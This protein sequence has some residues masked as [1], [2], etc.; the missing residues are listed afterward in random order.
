VKVEADRGED[1]GIVCEIVQVHDMRGTSILNK[2]KSST[3]SIKRIL[4]VATDYECD[5]LKT[6]MEEEINIVFTC[7]DI[8]QSVYYLPMSV[9]DAEY[10]FDR[11]KL[12]IYY[13]A[14]RRIDFRELVR[15]LFAQF[16]TRIW[17][18]H[19]TY[20]FR[21]HDGATAALATGNG[22]YF[23]NPPS[24]TSLALPPPVSSPNLMPSANM[25]SPNLLSPRK[26]FDLYDQ[27][28]QFSGGVDNFQNQYSGHLQQSNMQ[29][30]YSYSSPYSPSQSSSEI[31]FSN[32]NSLTEIF[33]TDKNYNDEVSTSQDYLQSPLLSPQ[34]VYSSP[35]SPTSRM[36]ASYGYNRPQFDPSCSSNYS[37]P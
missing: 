10:Q 5:Q 34:T 22:S 29:A 20:S 27:E 3:G 25:L 7:R 30:A 32:P 19:V 12:T 16:K 1:L 33:N 9:V 37:T 24:Q 13:E 28:R 18:E 15:D 31:M 6:K 4:R 36:S 35:L 8:S 21:P 26:N 17:M 11:H 2:L 14:S 23:C